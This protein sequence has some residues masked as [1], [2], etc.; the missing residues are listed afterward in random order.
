MN[1]G[2]P[3][4]TC[5]FFK[6]SD[7]VCRDGFYFR[8]NDSRTIARFK[9]C[10]CGKKFSSATFSLAVRQKKRRVN[11]PLFKLLA[12]G[13]SMRRA[14][15][16]LNIHRTTVKRKLIYLA[17]KARLAQAELLQ[18]LAQDKVILMQVDDL[19]TI[20]HTKLKPLSV[21]AAIDA[22]RRII[23]GAEVSKIPAFGH[24][25]ALSRKKYGKRE[26]QHPEGIKRLFCK[27]KNVIDDRAV[28]K[29]DEHQF[30]PKMIK[31]FFP[32]AVHKQYKGGRGSVTGQGELKKLTY[33]PLFMLNHTYAMLRA[34]I[35]RLFRKT[36]CTTKDPVMLKQH[37]DLY[38]QFHNQQLI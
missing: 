4:L 12:S 26:N 8:K 33:D 23:L 14:A 31:T 28:I 20:E 16:I 3:N 2:C 38:I 5:S 13:V 10:A 21:T 29:S 9:C 15:L 22:K 30:Y 36:W 7:F 17:A 35:N 27:I 25:A 19:I 24:L 1:H 11:Y 6:K 34:N 37:L 18:K 32:N